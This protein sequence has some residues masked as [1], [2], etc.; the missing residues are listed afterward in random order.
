M[1]GL[2][3]PPPVAGS[4]LG[5]QHLTSPVVAV[6]VVPVVLTAW[7]GAASGW[8]FGWISATCAWVMIALA[9][10]VGVWL[11]RQEA[12][13]Q[14]EHKWA[15]V[16][17]AR[18]QNESKATREELEE[19]RDDYEAL[20]RDA[21]THSADRRIESLARLLASDDGPTFAEGMAAG[22]AYRQ[23]LAEDPNNDRGRIG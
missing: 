3:D 22:R 10:R 20:K 4:L 17:I 1:S 9:A 6:V 23:E 21:K 5:R 19:L 18:L 16:M 8:S 14:W 13:H 11:H 15:L 7:G 2:P 12:M